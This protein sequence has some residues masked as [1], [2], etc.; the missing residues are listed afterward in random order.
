MPRVVWKGAITFGLVHIPV[1]LYPGSTS[2]ALDFD[3]LDKRDFAPIGYRRVNKR[4]GKEVA[5]DDTV[6]GYEYEDG[7]YVVMS[8]EDFKRANVKATQTV[9]IQAFVDAAEIPAYHFDTPYYL[10]PGKR[11]EKGYALLRETLRKTG[12]VGVANVVLRARQHLAVVMPVERLLLLN[13]L[14]FAGEIRPASRLHLP[15]SSLKAVGVSSKEAEMAARLVADMT[16]RWKPE[17]FKDTYRSDLLARI[18]QKVKARK[19]HEVTGPDEEAVPRRSAEIIDLMA[20][21]KKSLDSKG[22]R[23]QRRAAARAQS[24][25][26]RRSQP[27]ERRRRRA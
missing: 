10:E 20:A 24:T 12:R 14:R 7:R 17:A 18:R 5:L 15:G 2:A 1:S 4:T 23:P 19:T 11:G 16:E 21:L 22:E 6:K 25:R 26:A 8:E 9:D 3:L 27:L 13:T